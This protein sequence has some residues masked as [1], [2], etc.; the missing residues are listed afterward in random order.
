MGNKKV[1]PL[2]DTEIKNAKPKEKKY[3]LSDGNGLQLLV[4][5]DGKKIWE[6]RY[7]LA[8]R[9]KATTIGNYPLIKLADARERRN[10]FKTKIVNGIDP[11]QERKEIKSIIEEHKKGALEILTLPFK[12]KDDL[13]SLKT[14]IPYSYAY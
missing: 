6:I 12:N 13:L 10:S 9:P 8:G 3:V 7:T 14:S 5:P 11:V 2:S 1:V 4:K